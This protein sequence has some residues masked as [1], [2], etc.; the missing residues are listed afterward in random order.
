MKFHI[1]QVFD[2]QKILSISEGWPC[3]SQY[4]YC[5]QV[6]TSMIFLFSP[7]RL[8]G[9]KFFD[10]TR[11]GYMSSNGKGKALSLDTW[12][13][14]EGSRMLRVPDFKTIGT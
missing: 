11:R 3:V 14:P 5:V 1:L 12:T 10:Y 4:V 7:L 8:H 2:V 13:G 9:L 6:Y